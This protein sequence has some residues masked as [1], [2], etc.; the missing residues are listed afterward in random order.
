MRGVGWARFAKVV[1]VLNVVQQRIGKGLCAPPR[2]E[3]E[4]LRRAEGLAGS[5]L[6]DLAEEL[7]AAVPD[8]LLRAKGWIGNLVETMLGATAACRS[9]PDFPVLGVEL[10]TLPVG[11]DGQ[12]RES[13][14]VCTVPLLRH[15]GLTWK[16][17]CVYRK[18]KRVLWFPVQGDPAIP[19]ADRRLGFP[20]LWSPSVQEEQALRADWEELMETVALGQVD[21]ITAHHGSSLQIRPK[22]ANSRARRLGIGESGAR[23]QTLPR[24]FYLRTAFTAAILRRHFVMP[25]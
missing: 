22:A 21:S 5:R 23:I 15:N 13:T 11:S 20:L 10:K 25:R 3:L 16:A 1:A 2:T 24:G 12:P 19:L 14:Y 17:S 6:R 8:G 9:E 18:L 7:Q 4:L